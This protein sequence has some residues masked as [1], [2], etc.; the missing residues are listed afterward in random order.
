MDQIYTD[1]IDKIDQMSETDET[2]KF[3]TKRNRLD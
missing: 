1:N 2:S 3:P